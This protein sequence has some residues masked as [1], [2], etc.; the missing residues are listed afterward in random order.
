MIRI[1][2]VDL[3][4]ERF[5]TDSFDGFYQGDYY[6]LIENGD[7]I[8]RL[9]SQVGSEYVVNGYYYDSNKEEPVNFGAS[10]YEDTYVFVDMEL[11]PVIPEPP[12]IEEPDIKSII[13][14]PTGLNEGTLYI[15]TS[16]GWEE[17][18]QFIKK[19]D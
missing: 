19:G 15:V 17:L 1:F 4:G 11:K 14:L 9:T 18:E 12:V 3:G 10:V 6:L 13:N 5:N 7:T 2:Y 8:P 16:N